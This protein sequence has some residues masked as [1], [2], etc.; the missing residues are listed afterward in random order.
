M[1]KDLAAQYYKQGY[2]C[3]ESI[4]RAGNEYYNLGL[5]EKAFRMTGAFGGGLQVGDIC[6]ALSGSACVISS[7]YIETKAHECADLRPIM[8]KLVRA[9]QT[10]FSSRLCAQIKAKFYSKE[11]ACL[12]TVTTAAEVLE[13]TINE[14]EKDK[15]TK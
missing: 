5:D 14:Y 10:K 8:L 3:A 6:G 1:L 9:F 15:Q 2:N 11:V 13:E 4:T 12:N 7:K